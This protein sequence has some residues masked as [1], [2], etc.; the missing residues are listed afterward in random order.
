[1]IWTQNYPST[2]TSEMTDACFCP[3]PIQSEPFSNALDRWQKQQQISN[4]IISIDLSEDSVTLSDKKGLEVLYLEYTLDNKDRAITL[5][6]SQMLSEHTDFRNRGLMKLC[7]CLIALTRDA[8][9]ITYEGVL[10]GIPFVKSMEQEGLLTEVQIVNV[11]PH[12]GNITATGITNL[13]AM[14]SFCETK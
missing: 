4:S 2:S 6:I 7:Q 9:T 12:P 13:E 5:E 11:G 1:M 8:S 3:N 10:T 14:K